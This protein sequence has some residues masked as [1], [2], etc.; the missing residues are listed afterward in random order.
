MREEDCDQIHIKPDIHIISLPFQQSNKTINKE[1]TKK[2]KMQLISSSLS[3]PSLFTSKI[4]NGL[5][6]NGKKITSS[7]QQKHMS[8]YPTSNKFNSNRKRVSFN[9]A[10]KAWWIEAFALS[11]FE[12][13][14]QFLKQ[15]KKHQDMKTGY[16]YKLLKNNDIPPPSTLNN[17]FKAQIKIGIMNNNKST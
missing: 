2:R 1:E 17:W 15:V 8:P 11:K 3:Q 12:S 10:Q 4:Q 5:T 13:R 9:V 16:Y 7:H 14:P 6:S